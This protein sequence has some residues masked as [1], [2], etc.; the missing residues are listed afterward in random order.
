M[1]DASSYIDVL[2]FVADAPRS[3]EKG[4]VIF[5]EGDEAREMLILREGSIELRKGDHLL[6]TL[7]PGSIL[8]EMALIDPAP[9]SATA[10]AG[11]GCQV[12]SLDEKTFKE[13][14]Q[15]V[16]GFALELARTVVRRLRRELARS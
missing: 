9:R 4:A 15:R 7:Q 11:E 16:P 5:A 3:Y 6:E 2:M 8:G 10:V 1:V 13:L 14:V 12:I